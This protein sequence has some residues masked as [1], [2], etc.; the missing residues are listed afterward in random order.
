VGKVAV[1]ASSITAILL[2]GYIEWICGRTLR[3]R[4]STPGKTPQ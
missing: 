1:M 2:K 4:T 3:K